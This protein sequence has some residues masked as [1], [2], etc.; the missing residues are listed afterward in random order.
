MRIDPLTY[1]HF[2]RFRAATVYFKEIVA[3]PKLRS[4]FR[5]EGKGMG[6]GIALS[7]DAHHFIVRRAMQPGTTAQQMCAAFCGMVV[8]MAES[9]MNILGYHIEVE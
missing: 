2:R 1:E 9:H 8:H 3:K 6:A 5:R 7:V 4:M